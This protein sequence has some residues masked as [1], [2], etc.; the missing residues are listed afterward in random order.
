MFP[1][2]GFIFAYMIELLYTPVFPCDEEPS[3]CQAEWHN[4]AE[5]MKQKSF[6]ITYGC[7][8]LLVATAVGY[9]LLFYGFGTASE[10]MNKR[11]RDA[12]FISLIRQ[13]VAFF[14]LRPVA[15]ITSQLQEDAALLHAFSGEPIRTVIL[16]ATSV[17]VGVIVSFYFMWPFALVALGTIPFLAFGAEMEMRMYMGEDEGDEVAQPSEHSPGAIVIE[18]LLNIRTIASLTIEEKRAQELEDALREE[19]PHPLRSNAFKGAA[20]GLGQFFQFWGW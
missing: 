11:V 18:T 17:L 4:V 5:D 20:T 2:W 9:V 1:G 6:K 3:V 10:R 7:I 8:G 14:D 15:A 19:E 13:E 12:A 16:S